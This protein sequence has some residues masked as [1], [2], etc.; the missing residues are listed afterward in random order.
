MALRFLR[1]GYFV[2]KVGIGTASPT[3]KLD[4]RG[5][6]IVAL[7]TPST[8]Y[9]AATLEVYRNGNTSELLIHQDNG[10]ATTK[11]AQLH[12]RNGGN[13]T[14]LKTPTT[15]NGLI[16]DVES[17]VGAFVISTT[18]DVGIGTTNPG[19]KLHV[20]G[21]G[22][23]QGNLMVGSSGDVSGAA[24]Q[25]HIK[26]PN[27]QV[28]VLEDTDN[29]NLVVRL[30][31]EETV[32]FKIE[33]TTNSNVLFFGDEDGNVG[34]GT[35]APSRLL[36]VDGIQGWSEGTNIEKA[37]L[38]PTSTGT[39]FHLLGNN[40]NIRFDSRSGSNS[41]INTG[42]LGIGTTNP[43]ATLDIEN[44]T[45]VTVDI[46]SSSGDGQLRFQDNGITK[47]A[48]GRDNTQQDF[49]FSSSAGLST[50]PVVVL[51]HST[52]NVGIGT[53]TPSSTLQVNNNSSSL[54][55]EIRVTNNL[56]TASTGQS[57]SISLGREFED[58]SIR[59]SSVSNGPYGI[60]PDLVITGNKNA[61]GTTHTE[62]FR[63]KN[64]GN[65]GI[66][67]TSPLG[68]LQVNEYTVASQ[69]AQSV[70]GEVS[71]FNDSGS[72]ALYLGLRDSAYPNRGWSFNPVANGVNSDLQIKE[73]G[74]TGVRMTIKTTGNVGIGTTSP[75][76]KLDVR[77]ANVTISTSNSMSDG[78]RGLKIAGTNA[79]IEFAGAG[80]DF[81][82]SALADG[83]S[84]YDTTV[85]SYRFKIMNDGKVGIGTTSPSQLLHVAGNIRVTGEYYD[86]NNS[87]GAAGQILS[88][89]LTGTDWIDNAHI[90]SPA[91]V[92]PGSITSTIVGE[93]IEIAFNQSTTSNIDYYQVW[94]SDDGG[95]FGIIAQITPTD[96]SSTMTV[97]DTTFVTGGTM[98]YRVY[99]VKS[100]VYSSPGTTSI[101]YTVGALDVTDMTVINLN[102]AYY[103]QYEKPASRFID[104]IEIYMDSQT[105]QAA[106]NRSN[107]NIVYSGQN[108]SYMRSVGVSN[109]FHQ[110]WVEIVTT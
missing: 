29:A 66:G 40:G 41:Y 71:V 18:G 64:N 30:S 21:E 44:S 75:T 1:D 42:N 87:S 20:V 8:F 38:N 34:I 55:G 37:Y 106:L 22:K 89:T 98:S 88:A 54:G 76:G 53:V 61:V 70:H 2:G 3:T 68:K 100:G 77:E 11:F 26:G 74:L 31:A 84:I 94:S 107:A 97:V 96:F 79:A 83:L 102:T 32:G 9:S 82:V 35:T 109:N 108:P 23:I 104:H 101:V 36:D 67:T 57:A 72:Q 33:D 110:F 81:W 6:M 58:R 80:N 46:N 50:D 65:V 62:L 25:L 12:F 4:V 14:Y 5:G 60:N 16:I 95:D 24:G 19:Q 92:T 52:G 39:D 90:P 86:S 69:G 103:I 49:V 27:A 28:I 85:N 13:D 105:T 48:V 99:A 78:V 63:I 45:G 59:L 15:G 43:N 17:Q 56:S 10:A 51:K 93:T 7:D 47:W 91:P 73:H